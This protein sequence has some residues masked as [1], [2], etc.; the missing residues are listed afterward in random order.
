MV[1]LEAQFE[2]T[3]QLYRA[4]MPFIRHGGLFF[5]TSKEYQLGEIIT[6]RYRLP[7][8]NEWHTFDGL[9][10]W[11]NPLGSQGGRPPGVGLGFQIENNPHKARIEKELV[12]EAG[13]EQL[14]STM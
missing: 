1:A 13:S 6:A 12:G 14:T 11:C 10:V 7:G 9:V 3:T 4:Y 2:T 5:V 8:D